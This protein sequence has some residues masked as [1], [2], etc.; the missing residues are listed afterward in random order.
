MFTNA[1]QKVH[2]TIRQWFEVAR[3]LT[4]PVS[5][6]V[7]VRIDESAHRRPMSIREYRILNQR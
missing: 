3:F 7:R 5:I 1:Y 2:G 4:G 6:P